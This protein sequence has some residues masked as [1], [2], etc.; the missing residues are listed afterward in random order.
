MN[1][2]IFFLIAPYP[3]SSPLP[4]CWLH[5]KVTLINFYFIFISFLISK[6]ART[7]EIKIPPDFMRKISFL[8][9]DTKITPWNDLEEI[10]AHLCKNTSCTRRGMNYSYLHLIPHIM[11]L[12]AW[13]THFHNRTAVNAAL[14]QILWHHDK[15]VFTIDAVPTITSS[16]ASKHKWKWHWLRSAPNHLCRLLMRNKCCVTQIQAPY[17]YRLRGRRVAPCDKIWRKLLESH[18]LRRKKRKVRTLYPS[19]DKKLFTKYFNR[20]LNVMNCKGEGR[21]TLKVLTSFLSRGENGRRRKK[22]MKYS[23]NTK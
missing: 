17:S 12:Q 18:F 5:Q 2:A 10:R 11:C 4:L 15:T 3:P 22:S 13:E 9:T 7:P 1:R 14:K 6:T 8:M 16:Q 23:P 20:A 21:R 19:E